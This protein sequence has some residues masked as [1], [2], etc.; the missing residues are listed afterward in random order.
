MAQFK[1]VENNG[2]VHYF[3]SAAEMQAWIEE[4]KED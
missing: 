3:N 1:L 2:T 4:N